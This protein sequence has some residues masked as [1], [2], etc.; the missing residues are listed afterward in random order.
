MKSLSKYSAT[1]T[2]IGSFTGQSKIADNNFEERKLSPCFILW[3]GLIQAEKVNRKLNVF[4]KR[5]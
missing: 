5:G 3:K 4:V 1:E 2:T